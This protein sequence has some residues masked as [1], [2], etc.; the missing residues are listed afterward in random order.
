MLVDSVR[1]NSAR[2]AASRPDIVKR[3]PPARLAMKPETV[4]PP[5]SRIVAETAGG[6]R[7]DQGHGDRLAQGPPESE[8]RPTHDAPAPEGEHHGADHPPAG[9]RR[10]RGRPP[11]HPAGSARRPRARPRSRSAAP[12]ATRRCPAMKN[13]PLQTGLG[14]RVED[15]DPAKVIRQPSRRRVRVC[16]RGIRNPHSP[17]SRLGTAASRSTMP[18]NHRRRPRARVLGDE[19]RTKNAERN[20]DG[21]RYQG[22]DD[23]AHQQAPHSDP[24]WYDVGA[25]LLTG[26]ELPGS[27]DL[28]CVAALQE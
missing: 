24:R 20:R 23:G 3:S 15:R 11:S 6:L 28:E 21:H 25:P 7:Q 8:H 17:K 9:A 5:F 22:D 1:T 19:Q 12:S 18:V 10:G 16:R 4:P 14:L 2:P 13:D 26:Q 27:R